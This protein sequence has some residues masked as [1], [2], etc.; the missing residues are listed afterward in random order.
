MIVVSLTSLVAGAIGMFYLEVRA[1]G[2]TSE[3]LVALERRASLIAGW[4]GR[5]LRGAREVSTTQGELHIE[6]PAGPVRYR[7]VEGRL[8]R[9][10][11]GRDR[12]LATGARL[13]T[14]IAVDG[15]HRAEIALE[16]KI[17]RKRAV[18]LRR[19]IFVGARA[20]GARP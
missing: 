3:A 6:G 18:R 11:R 16:R 8:E 19:E 9:Q 10:A 20:S 12:V 2:A 4:L 17:L 5:D 7:V 15:G 14:V 1:M 13:P